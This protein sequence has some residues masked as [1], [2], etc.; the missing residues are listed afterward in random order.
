MGSW[1]SKFSLHVKANLVFEME[2]RGQKP[3][4]SYFNAVLNQFL[5]ELRILSRK[6]SPDKLVG[7]GT[8]LSQT[9]FAR[10][11][12]TTDFRSRNAPLKNEE[13]KGL[14]LKTCTSIKTAQP[15]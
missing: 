4:Y 15:L 11:H 7:S 12:H 10:R 1:E 2:N 14:E 8:C 5:S 3:N 9:F 13:E 6:G